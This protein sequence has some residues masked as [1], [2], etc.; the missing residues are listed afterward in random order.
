MCSSDLRR[1]KAAGFDGIQ[2]HCAHGYLLAQFISPLF[3]LRTDEYGGS[4]QNR[5]RFVVEVY[6][7]VRQEV[8]TDY[9]IWIKMN[10]TDEQAD[11]LT[12]NDFI[13]M[14][15]ILSDAGIDAIEVSGNR[16]SSHT[17]A[18]RAYYQEAA[19]HL[20]A[21]VTTPIILTGGMREL[22]MMQTISDTSNV[23][24]FGF[25]RPLI[26]EPNFVQTLK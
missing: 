10:S 1:A 8:G 11:G 24:L 6:Q 18:E 9:P 21:H 7:A 17:V 25:S 14:A 20:A 19:K 3:N 26:K 23:N 2:L 15:T 4:P 22:D 5:V 12:L 16:W 13:E